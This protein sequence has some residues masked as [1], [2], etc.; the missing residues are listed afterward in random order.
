MSPSQEDNDR[1][2]CCAPTASTPPHHATEPATEAS[3]NQVLDKTLE[4]AILA[5]S[6]TLEPTTVTNRQFSDFVADSGYRTD[7]E[8]WGASFVFHL[9]LA[10]TAPATQAVVGAEWWRLVPGATWQHP[11]GPGS[12]IGDRPDHPVVHVSWYDAM[13]YCAWAGLVLPT[14]QEWEYAAR[15]GHERRE[16]P[17]GHELTPGG[18]HMMNVWQGTFPS[19]NSGDDGFIGTA[20]VRS[21]PANDYGLYEMTGNVWE[22]T[23]SFF[24]QEQR[25]LRGGSY[26]CHASYCRRYTVTGR[27]GN[28]PDSTSGNMGFRCASL[29]TKS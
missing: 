19:H 26:L 25:V 24:D 28:T 20:P 2:S 15:A 10:P 1:S 5:R 8:E 16:F 21:F 23:S 4:A 17:W 29:A 9:L 27:M 22:W 13:A 18:T 11:E 12:D 6:R 3:Q 14:E 7:A